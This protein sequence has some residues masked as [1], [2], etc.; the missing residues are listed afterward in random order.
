MRRGSISDNVS[1]LNSDY[2]VNTVGPTT[3]QDRHVAD[4]A[5]WLAGD[6]IID[7]PRASGNDDCGS[8]NDVGIRTISTT[9]RVA[10]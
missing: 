7:D 10:I 1:Y 4:C 3:A 6:A 5:Q 8:I 2:Y 9:D